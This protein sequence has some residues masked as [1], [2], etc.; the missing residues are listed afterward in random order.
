MR[1]IAL[2]SVAVLLIAAHAPLHAQP[3]TRSSVVATVDGDLDVTIGDLNERMPRLL[4]SGVIDP[5]KRYQ[6][7]LNEAVI[8]RLKGLDFFRLGYQDDPAFMAA[9]GLRVTEEILVAYYEQTYEQAYLNDAALR[10]E[11]ERMGRVVQVRQIVRDVPDDATAETVQR[12]RETV[13]TIR[14]QLDEGVPAEDLVARYSQNEASAQAGGLSGPI[15]WE[16]STQS[17]IGAAAFGLDPGDAVSLETRDAFVVLVGDRVGRVEL[18]PFEAVRDRLVTVQKGRYAD[19]SN[20]AYYAERQGMVDS[21]SVRWN[22]DL[23]AQVVD[24]STTP[25]FFEGGYDDVIDGYLASRGD[26]V[27]FT[28]SAGELR[29]SELPRL[30]REVLVLSGDTDGDV[31][32]VQ[33][34]LLE[35]VRADR[36]ARLGGEIGLGERL[37]RPGSPSPILADVFRIYYDQRQI[38]DRIPDPTE[39]ALR[40]FY[41]AHADSLFYQLETVYTEVIEREDKEEI[42]RVWARVQDGAPFSEVSN[43]RL[44]RS[45]ERSRDGEVVTRNL[46]EPPYMGA[47][48]IGLSPGETTG[49]VAYE[50][51]Q[52]PRYGIALVTRRLNERPLRYDEVR[53]RVEEAFAEHHRARLAAEVEAEL[54]RRYEVE[55]DDALWARVLDATP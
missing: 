30:I 6:A 9:H 12:I 10:R 20:E 11:H 47:A 52:G 42:D 7:A 19:Q 8:E 27:L 13:G 46:R 50:T 28:D 41:E 53:D 55:V 31:E 45:F 39:A 15:T 21:V 5:T 44:V 43:R 17:A 3:V 14:R 54:R 29:L 24:W 34:Y 26:A 38:E 18:P 23:L 1:R 16:Q 4:Y 25:G 48:A 32:L 2:C 49:P 36:M 35:A 33:D 37:L 40:A 22:A 51:P